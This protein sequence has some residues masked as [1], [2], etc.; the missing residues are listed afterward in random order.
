MKKAKIL[1][2][3]DRPENLLA[4]SN[5][6]AANGVETLTATNG[7]DALALLLDND[8]AL[9]M[10]DV[11]MPGM[12]GYELAHLMRTSPRS[13]SVPIIFVTAAKIGEAGVF[14][15]YD[16][17]AVDF[18]HKPL[19]PLIVRS[20][21]LVFLEL[22]WRS[23]E[24]EERLNEVGRLRIEAEQASVAKSQFLANMSHEIRTPIGAILGYGEILQSSAESNPI[25]LQCSAAILRN[26]QRLHGL[27]D[28][29]LD[30]ARIEAGQIEV[31]K[32]TFSLLELITD[33][34]STYAPMAQEKG[35]TFSV[36]ADS[37]LPRSITTDGV[38]L[39][40][41]VD[42]LVANAIKFTVHGEIFVRIE[43]RK[44]SVERL[45]FRISDTGIGISLHKRESLFRLFSQADSSSSRPFGG[46]G[47]G[48]FIARKLAE[49]LGGD[50][51]LENSTP[52]AGSVF[53]LD[54][55]P[56]PATESD[57]PALRRALDNVHS[58]RA[59]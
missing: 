19:E 7:D 25:V 38:R 24:L 33:L 28:D 13:R 57:H 16:K 18:L 56:S 4:L 45:S 17:G 9:A 58:T 49:L 15:G 3:D 1:L 23:Q 52:G 2:V 43:W 26:A 34:K 51:T 44:S 55:D 35:V 41:I 36:V 50:V 46:T 27:V 32:E 48:L 39:K 59:H 29:I 22:Y 47:A 30:L 21:V 31:K 42:H 54:I 10:L 12:S 14:E 53:R 20:K 37:E 40:Q 8:I 11:Q 6:I 5:L